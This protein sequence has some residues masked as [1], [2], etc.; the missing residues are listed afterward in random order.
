MFLF[1][2]VG[3]C[4]R[5][6]MDPRCHHQ[7][8]DGRANGQRVPVGAAV[9]PVRPQTHLLP[10]FIP[11]RS[12]EHHC[13]ILNLL[14]NVCWFPVP[15]WIC[16]RSLSVRISLLHHWVYPQE[17]P[18]YAPSDSLL[19]SSSR[20]IRALGMVTPGLEA[21]T[22]SDGSCSGAISPLLVVSTAV[23]FQLILYF[24]KNRMNWVFET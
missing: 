22:D 8:P 19:V 7:H 17:I 4:L 21:S 20:C 16:C 11:A 23:K 12:V 24:S 1:C 6:K 10:V 9:G 14:A 18:P 2:T 3:S 5:Q 15:Y 13:R